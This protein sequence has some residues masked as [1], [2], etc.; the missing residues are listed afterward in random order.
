M[1]L[2]K[3]NTKYLKDYRPPVYFIDT[4]ELTFDLHE[5]FCTVTSRLTGKR[6][7]LSDDPNNA[8]E[9]D[10]KALELQSVKLNGIEL[11]SGDYLLDDETLVIQQVPDDYTLEI[12]TRIYPQ[13]NTSLEG[14][15]KSNGMFCTQCEAQGFRKITYY[16]DRPDVMSK[17]TTRIIANKNQYPVLLSNGNPVEK[18]SEGPNRHWIKWEDP[19]KKPSYLFAL[20]A[21]QLVPFEDEFVTCSGKTV[22][23]QIF[24]KQEDIDRCAHAME[25]LKQS[26]KWDEQVYKR[27]YDLDIFMIV[28]VNDF[29]AGAM[30]NKGL[31]IFNSSYVLAKPETA[32]D[33]DYE[34]IQGVIA[35]EYFHNWTGNRITCRD[36][37]QLSLKEGFTIFR[38]QNFS[39]DMTSKT[40]KR[41][42]DVKVLRT[43]QFAEDSGPMAHQV[44]PDSVIEINNF[45]T[46]T[47]YNKGAELIRMMYTMLGK[48]KF[49]QGVALYFQRHDGQAVTTEDFVKSMEDASQTDLKQFRRWYTQAGTPEIRVFTEYDETSKTFTL[50]LKQSCPDTPGQKNKLPF[51]IPVVMGL[52]GP[53]GQDTSLYLENADPIKGEKQAVLNFCQEEQ[54]FRFTNVA[55]KPYLSIFRD[56]SAPVKVVQDPS[57][58]ELAFLMSHDTDDFNRWEASQQFTTSIILQLVKACQK[59]SYDSQQLKEQ[60]RKKLVTLASAFEKILRETS[61]DKAFTAQLLMLPPEAYIAEQMEQ[62]D[63][64]NIHRV[65]LAIIESLADTF[66]DLFLKIYQKNHITGAYDSHPASIGQRSLKNLALGYLMSLDSSDALQLCTQQFE[67]ANNMTD[68]MQALTYLAEKDY[69]G[70]KAA[71]ESFGEKW[72][73]DALVMN[74]WFSIQSSSKLTTLAEVKNLMN[75]S[76]FNLKNPNNLRAVIGTFCSINHINFHV[77][78][79]ESYAFL[80]DQIL[81]LDKLNPMIAARLITPLSRWRKYNS[82][83][84]SLIKKQLKR[85][86]D[87]KGLSKNVYEIA[88]KSLD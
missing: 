63:V 26:M 18:G 56:F 83:R 44:R 3:P 79:G 31:N 32:T 36:W 55:E 15:Y 12:V 76:A 53:D 40:V 9:L 61:L 78:S 68:E 82:K 27:E 57:E 84:Q 73:N 30:E 52:V 54:S 37:F 2:Q 42:Q 62:V 21:G 6:N 14:L 39:A 4:T 58:D 28:A 75:Q 38:D 60:V 74:I 45:Y 88:S 50:T 17:F 49:Y 19:F 51:H 66:Q 77:S 81:I 85:I 65:R 25:C 86:L 20:V 8:F 59:T 87:A 23:L 1:T 43:I 48:E 47:I 64:E 35:H 80:A 69:P 10:G 13:K 46:V 41:I 34:K 72:Q 11:Q 71:I 70:R 7:P 67:Q 29:N 16:P 33:S 5:E 24:V 22:K